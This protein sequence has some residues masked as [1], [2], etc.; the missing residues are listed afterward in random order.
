MAREIGNGEALNQISEQII[1]LTERYNRLAKISE[2][3]RAE[4]TA[5]NSII[6][7]LKNDIANEIKLLNERIID[8]NSLIISI[9]TKVKHT[10]SKFKEIIK[11]DALAKLQRRVDGLKY[12][13]FMTKKEL[14]E[15]S[16][17]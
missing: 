16:N 1:T 6:G 9:Q 8:I 4:T 14:D 10:S 3:Q 11:K 5:R 12:E 7:G 2:E 13:Q 17:D 15:L